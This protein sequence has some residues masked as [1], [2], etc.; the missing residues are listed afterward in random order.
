MPDRDPIIECNNCGK[1][2]FWESEYRDGVRVKLM[3]EG[4]TRVANAY[5]NG[6]LLL[7]CS[8][9]PCESTFLARHADATD[10]PPSAYIVDT[11]DA[12]PEP[13]VPEVP[14]VVLTGK[15]AMCECGMGPFKTNGIHGHRRSKVHKV[16]MAGGIGVGVRLLQVHAPDCCAHQ[17]AA[18]ANLR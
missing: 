16:R 11:A 13:S 6:T 15:R 4:W 14:E 7:F 10:Y 12:A 5:G 18:P 2:T 8:S 3:P 17:R 9:F 1:E